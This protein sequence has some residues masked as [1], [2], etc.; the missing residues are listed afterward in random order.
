MTRLTEERKKFKSTAHWYKSILDAIPIPISVTDSDA[1]WTFVNTR[2]ENFLG[3]KFDDIKGKSCS[4]WGAQIC[5][6]PNC[7][8]ECAKR[9]VKQT[10]FTHNGASYI[11]D[12]EILKDINENTA[13]YIEIVQDV[14]QLEE[15]SKKQMDAEALNK[16][17]STF[18]TTV[19]HEIRT[20]LN[21]I[22][23]IADIEMQDQSHTQKTREALIKIHSA[24]NLL[25]HIINDI[26]DLSKIEA[27]KLEL[28]C[29]DYN[30]PNLINDIIHINIVRINNKQIEFYLNINENIPENLFGD[31]I[32]IRQIL[33][34]ILSNAFKYTERGNVTLSVDK[35]N[36]NGVFTLI[37]KISDTGQGMT[38]DEIN[39]MFNEYTR[40]HKKA[41]RAIEGTGIGMSITKHLI[42]LMNGEIY[43]DSKIGEGTTFTIKLPQETAGSSIIGKETSENL[44]KFRYESS[45]A[46]R[47]A[48]I[49]REPM[50]YGRVLI[51]D[52]VETNLYVAK[53]FLLP[54]KLNISFAVNGFETI[55]KIKN[56]EVYDVIFMDH[57]MPKMDGVETVKKIR[58]IGYPHP[59]IALT[60][61]ALVGQAEI[62]LDNGFNDFIS[63]PIDI[64]QLNNLLNK[65]VRDKQPAEV[66]EKARLENQIDNK[67]NDI[68]QK[69]LDA[70][71][72]DIFIRDAEKS[73]KSLEIIITNNFDNNENIKDYIIITHSMKSALANINEQELSDIA[74]KLEQA[75]KNNKIDVILSDT[76][77]FIKSLRAL[78]N[79]LRE[80]ND[81]AEAGEDIEEDIAFLRE[82]LLDI[83]EACMVYDKKNIK[84]TIFILRERPWSI[85]VTEML[86][87]IS[88]YLLH[89]DYEKISS[90]IDKKINKGA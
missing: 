55:D 31:E 79:S 34:N 71:L 45:P 56:G 42:R 35:E 24:G 82:K 25:L 49:T 30:V 9:G 88:E 74:Y 77:G 29:A 59:I 28:S 75:G 67:K 64:R 8:I 3:V 73:I 51:V 4:N 69:I 62:F 87:N 16:A 27:G 41:N 38:H 76:F 23:G 54:Y 37:F 53:G 5:N 58:E 39:N 83:K 15:M 70:E 50:P 48:Q 78:I 32:R 26:L 20:P 18:L 2:V 72:S 17:K 6:T 84:N 36:N 43:I 68:T 46:I 80:K 21:A 52:D 90:I 13:G 10:Y 11:V 47:N 22:L 65:F 14:T 60:A 81:T 7:G 12:V 40:F 33:N 86:K 57:M 85:G 19:S 1:C 66:I 44:K 61:N 63:K 89:S